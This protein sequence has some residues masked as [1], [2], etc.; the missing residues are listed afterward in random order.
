[1]DVQ[2][3]KK[4]TKQPNLTADP[5]VLA[6]RYWEYLAENPRRK[7]EKWNT[8]YSNLLANQPD[9]HVDSMTDRARAIRYAK[10]H[11]ECFYEVRDLKRIV[12]W[13]DKAS[14]TSQK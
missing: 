6:H 4:T 12:E 13:L 9:P 10:E 2:V 3:P 8:Y 11:H 5:Y 1:M 14:A 7:G